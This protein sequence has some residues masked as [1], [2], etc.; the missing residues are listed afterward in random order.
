MFLMKSIF[1]LCLEMCHTCMVYMCLLFD[2]ETLMD[3]CVGI[4]MDLTVFMEGMV[5]VIAI[6]KDECY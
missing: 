2:W 6:W 1:M 4:L 5:L 3:L